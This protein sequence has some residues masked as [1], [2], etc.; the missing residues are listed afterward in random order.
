[1]NARLLDIRDDANQEFFLE[2]QQF[3]RFAGH[4]LS[5]DVHLERRTAG[6]EKSHAHWT[7]GPFRVATL[8]FKLWTIPAW[9]ERNQEAA[10]QLVIVLHAFHRSIALHSNGALSS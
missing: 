9:L 5:N 8:P 3:R 7:K 2:L 4:D 6:A 1:L 10:C